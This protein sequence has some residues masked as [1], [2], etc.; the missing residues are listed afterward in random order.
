M[1][2]SMF[3]VPKYVLTY[4]FNGPVLVSSMEA[5]GDKSHG[6]TERERNE[7]RARPV[8]DVANIYNKQNT[9]LS[10]CPIGSSAP[11]SP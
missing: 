8:F 2:K 1:S 11:W 3:N 4:Q 10:S 6:V 7:G 5:L 9:F